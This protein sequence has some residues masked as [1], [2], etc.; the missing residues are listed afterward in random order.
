MQKHIKD[1]LKHYIFFFSLFYILLCVLTIIGFVDI[2][3]AIGHSMYPTMSNGTTILLC[4]KSTNYKIGDIIIYKAPKGRFYV[5]NRPIISI[6]HRIV[7]KKGE[8]YITKGDNNK[9]TDPICVK[10]DDIICKV[11]AWI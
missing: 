7:G 2:R 8:C 10:V 9:Y 4:I 1:F 6:A 3:R 5:G 11:V